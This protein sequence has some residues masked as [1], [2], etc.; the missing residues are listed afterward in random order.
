MEE[1]LELPQCEAGHKEI[2]RNFCRSI[3]FGEELIVPGEEG[4]WSVEFI[5]ALI[6]S[7]KKGKSVNIPIDREEYED[8][9]SESKQTSREKR[10]RKVKRVTDPRHLK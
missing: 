4:L 10:V 2:M 3:L 5:N 9:L 8:L 6:L 1:K 7:G